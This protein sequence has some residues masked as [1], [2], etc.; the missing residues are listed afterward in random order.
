[1]YMLVEL[2]EADS[3]KWLSLLHHQAS[4]EIVGDEHAPVVSELPATKRRKQSQTRLTHQQKRELVDSYLE[5]ATTYELAAQYGCHRNTV[6]N[7]LKDR[8]V[9]L[10]CE[11]MT[12]SQIDQAVIHYEGGLSLARVGNELGFDDG[13]IRHRLIERGVYMR[14]SHGRARSKK[15]A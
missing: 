10:R 5:G 15:E 7:V 14:D 2:S 8:G 3:K 1:M 13:T 12:E 6:S 11:S 4:A 9:A